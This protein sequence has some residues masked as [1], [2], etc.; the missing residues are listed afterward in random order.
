MELRQLRYFLA[1]AEE[2][3]FGRAAESLGIAQPGLSQQIKVLERRVGAQLFDREVR[4]I[5]LTAAGEAL[6][7]H[8]RIVIEAV[9][10][11]LESTR[12]SALGAGGTLKVGTPLVGRFPVMTE[13]VDVFRSRFPGV[14]LQL[15]PG[16]A[17]HSIDALDR[18]TLDL[19]IVHAPFD[20]PRTPRYQRLG[21][22]E[23]LVLLPEGHRLSAL[24]RLPR[25]E[26]LGERFLDWPRTLNPTLMDHVRLATFGVA[27]HPGRVEVADAVDGPSRAPL[28]ADGLGIAVDAVPYPAEV[29]PERTGV[30]Y[31]RVEDPPPLIE[32]G[33]IWYEGELSSLASA[34]IELAT[35]LVDTDHPAGD[36]SGGRI[37]A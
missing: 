16:L 8:A 11:A 26:L 36:V 17:S 7:P 25:A 4:P 30:V 12:E 21:A 32:H 34:F 29:L 6:L 13:L 5:A 14:E 18:G 9:D 35:G 31:R 23:I 24:D 19:A 37:P 33:L 3:H 10:R 1:L 27:E 22:H 20:A 2:R 15:H 28:V